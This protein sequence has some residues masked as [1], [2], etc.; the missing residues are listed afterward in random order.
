LADRGEGGEG[1]NTHETV[2]RSAVP[3]YCNGIGAMATY[4]LTVV[5]MQWRCERCGARVKVVA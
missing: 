4:V 1:V 3:I 5:G 2:K